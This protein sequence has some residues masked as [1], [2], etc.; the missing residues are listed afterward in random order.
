M[1]QHIYGN[2]LNYKNVDKKLENSKNK[3]VCRD[4][5]LCRVFGIA[6]D[7]ACFGKNESG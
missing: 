3:H 7:D 5:W 6:M 4:V 2:V 1:G